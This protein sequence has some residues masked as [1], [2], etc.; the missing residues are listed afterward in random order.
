M[1]KRI[2]IDNQMDLDIK[3]K[4]TDA[5]SVVENTYNPLAE[6]IH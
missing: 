2:L 3:I 1:Y 4:K 6:L 5:I